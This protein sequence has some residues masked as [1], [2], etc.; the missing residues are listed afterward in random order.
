MIM[1]RRR[2]IVVCDSV[3]CYSEFHMYCKSREIQQ[4]SPR[5]GI[6]LQDPQTCHLLEPRAH[7]QLAYCFHEA[8]VARLSCLA[9]LSERVK[10]EL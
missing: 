10:G 1:V 3:V 9:K 7:S 2:Y 4:L 6:P 8:F 5:L